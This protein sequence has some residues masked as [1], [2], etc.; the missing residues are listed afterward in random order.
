MRPQ[1]RKY[2]AVQI[3]IIT[4]EGSAFRKCGELVK[5]VAAVDAACIDGERMVSSAVSNSRMGP[6]VLGLTRLPLLGVTNSPSG[7]G[8]A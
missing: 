5:V 6:D 2:D 3:E 7:T 8:E 1:R 4:V